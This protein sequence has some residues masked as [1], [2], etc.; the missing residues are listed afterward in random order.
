M[1]S[2]LGADHTEHLLEGVRA[3]IAAGTPLRIHGADTK[4]DCIGRTIDATPLDTRL[5]SGIVNYEPAELVLTAR[6]G[7]PLAA[8]QAATAAEGQALACEPPV[9][10]GKATLGGTL[11]SNLSGPARPWSGSIRDH[12]LGIKLINGK[13]QHLTFGGQVMKNVAGYDVSRAQAGALGTL[14]VITEISVKVM[15]LPEATAT[16]RYEMSA[17]EALNT[18]NQ[19]AT[20]PKP[21]TGACWYEGQLF[22]RLG[23]TASAVEH[24]ARQWG[25]ER[26]DSSDAPWAALREQQLPFFAGGQPLWRLSISPTTPLFLE[27]PTV[28]DWGG[29]ARWLRGEQELDL[30]HSSCANAG[31]YAALFSG[32]DRLGEVRGQMTATE[33]RLH[34]RLKAAF[35]PDGIFNPGRLYSW[36]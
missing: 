10:G 13:A 3:A 19:R 35:D 15:P 25:G 27:S 9:Y 12:V 8:L 23:G 5:H 2:T 18:M 4:R 6:A 33:K 34:Q 26:L 28:I 29:A 36:L 22:L 17:Q 30:L 20:Q 16:L 7:T 32:G 31:G 1:S 14:G 21:L 24:T 11:A